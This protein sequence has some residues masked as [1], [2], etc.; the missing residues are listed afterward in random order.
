MVEFE[1]EFALAIPVPSSGV[2]NEATTSSMWGLAD[3]SRSSMRVMSARVEGGHV[4][5][6]GKEK[7]A[8]RMFSDKSPS[9]AFS[10]GDHCG[11]GAMEQSQV[12]NHQKK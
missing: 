4:E 1:F 8:E 5:V 9:A 10:K 11:S 12:T 6:M 7:V 3:D 2:S